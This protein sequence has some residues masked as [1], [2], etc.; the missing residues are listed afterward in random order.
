MQIN[1]IDTSSFIA[2]P[3][4]LS[5]TKGCNV[6]IYPVLMELDKLKIFPDITGE[7]ARTAIKEIQ[8]VFDSGKYALRNESN[9]FSEITTYFISNLYDKKYT[10]DTKADEIFIHFLSEITS[11]REQYEADKT[12]F[13]FYT[14]DLS[15]SLLAKTVISDFI[16]IKSSISFRDISEYT[17]I[18]EIE[19]NDEEMS[20]LSNGSLH[21]S[22]EFTNDWDTN[23]YV[24]CR[25]LT[26]NSS[27]LCVFDKKIS[28]I[29]LIQDKNRYSFFSISPKNREQTFAMDA[30]MNDS[31]E[32]LSLS[33][34]AGSGKTL[35]SVAYGLHK[36]FKSDFRQMVILKPLHTVG[37]DVGFLPGNIEEKMKPWLGSVWDAIEFISMNCQAKELVDGPEGLLKRHT[38]Q[39]DP[40]TFIRG[41]TYHNRF[42]LIDEAQN[43]TPTEMRTILTRVGE[44]CK[45]VI[46]GDPTQ[47][48]NPKCTRLNNGLTYFISKMKHLPITSHVS[49]K[50]TER[51]QLAKYAAELL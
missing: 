49:F 7:R 33:G 30:L 20:S 8:K 40:I 45:V 43:L 47:I 25:S 16:E 9:N 39:I 35:L 26:S 21:I 46:T 36:V 38:L 3:H 48:D 10:L 50:E 13:V 37:K 34:V 14:E 28:N 32:C 29:S 15:L 44:K 22:S 1:F 51:S 18:R 4:I 5:E 41:K 6:I 23:E 12:R 31:V 42:I 11:R 17:G 27:R 24:H 19:L 2:N